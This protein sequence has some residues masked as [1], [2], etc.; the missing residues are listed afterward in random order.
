M[1]PRNLFVIVVL[2]VSVA[3]FLY[4]I[5]ATSSSG[6]EI[7]SPPSTRQYVTVLVS[8]AGLFSAIGAIVFNSLS[9]ASQNKNQYY[10]I[11]KDFE[12][13]YTKLAEIESQLKD[14]VWMTFDELSREPR[15]TIEDV[16][17]YR[18]KFYQFHERLSHLALKGI[19]PKEIARY[20]IF[21][22]GVNLSYIDID[23]D[24]DLLKK[25]LSYTMRWCR[26][27]GIR[28]TRRF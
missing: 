2:S 4:N 5:Q 1:Q 9:Q 18:W 20:Y 15:E 11:L 7:V 3:L 12:V 6:V 22:Y 24:P 21:S 26:Q 25:E 10:Q 17:L 14:Y 27:E 8:I 19:I 23:F 16:E 28:K 13:E